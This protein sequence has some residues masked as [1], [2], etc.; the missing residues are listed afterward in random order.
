MAGE[1]KE[2]RRRMKQR[3]GRYLIDEAMEASERRQQKEKMRS[4]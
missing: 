1:S 4:E 2:E 3:R